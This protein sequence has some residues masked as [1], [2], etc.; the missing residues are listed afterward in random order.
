VTGAKN[1][2][3]RTDSL[4]FIG[5]DRMLYVVTT[6][7]A[8]AGARRTCV[9]D[10]V[11]FAIY[12]SGVVYSSATNTSFT[13]YPGC[14]VGP[15]LVGVRATLMTPTVDSVLQYQ[16]DITG[17]RIVKTANLAPS[18]GGAEVIAGI[19]GN[20]TAM[21]ADADSV[22]WATSD[23]VRKTPRAGGGTA[24]VLAD[25][26]KQPRTLA[27]QGGDIFWTNYDDGTVMR[28]PTNG[29]SP[30]VA[31]LRDLKSPWGLVVT[32]KEIFVAVY[33]E[34]RVLRFRRP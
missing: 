8:G 28:Q 30:P 9:S 13:G 20:V 14:G 12:N 6:S 26:Q 18:A 7:G 21:I 5:D 22:Y 17:G 27:L 32:A 23:A 11:S 2:V 34:N 31:I 24:T 15:N 19:G 16:P 10:V 1:F 33:G 25:G 4:L 3:A 29:S